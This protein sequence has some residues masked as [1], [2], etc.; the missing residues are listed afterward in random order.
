ML[1]T[2]DKAFYRSFSALFWPL[3]LQNVINLSVNLA[4]NVMLGSLGPHP[5]AALAGATVVNIP[6]LVIF[7]VFQRRFIEGIATTGIK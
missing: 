5:E 2:R 7:L 4:D 6:V 1:L 3:V